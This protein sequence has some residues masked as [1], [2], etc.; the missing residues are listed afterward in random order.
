MLLLCFFFFFFFFFLNSAEYTAIYDIDFK[1]RNN[2]CSHLDQWTTSLVPKMVHDVVTP[3][4]GFMKAGIIVEG[5]GGAGMG[6]GVEGGG[7][8]AL[9]GTGGV[10]GGVVEG[11]VG[12]GV[13]GV[14]G[15]AVGVRGVGLRVIAPP[16][17]VRS[18]DVFIPYSDMELEGGFE[19]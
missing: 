14:G 11:V 19:G 4:V 12:E 8:G 3:N 13:G 1:L 10:V 7:S 2:S 6:G 17:L 5:G 15:T 18:N 9:G 16:S